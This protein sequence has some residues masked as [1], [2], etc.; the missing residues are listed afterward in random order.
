MPASPRICLGLCLAALILLC[1]GQLRATVLRVEAP[2]PELR[3][4]L[5]DIF[6]KNQPRLEELTGQV[7][8]AVT[9]EAPASGGA[10]SA[11]LQQLG[12]PAWAAGVALPAYHLIL[13]KP[14]HLLYGG[15]DMESLLVHE[16]AHLY[17]SQALAG[18]KAPWW[19]SEGLA[20]L[21]AKESSLGRQYT[22]GKAVFNNGLLP[23]SLMDDNFF[24]SSLQVELAYAE[25]YY[26]AQFLEEQAPGAL[27]KIISGLGRGY[28]V[29]RCLF[30]ATGKTLSQ[31]EHNFAGAMQSRFYW[32]AFGAGGGLW[33]FIA[34]LAALA[35]VWR[36]RRIVRQMRQM[37]QTKAVIL[38]VRSP[39]ARPG[40]ELKMSR[41]MLAQRPRHL[42]E[43]LHR[44]ANGR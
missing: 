14:P 38:L 5:E 31:W 30:E 26:M 4:H 39:F 13:I 28:D 24:P 1:A 35:L 21:A 17:I 7:L 43:I 19:L 6:R 22:M 11:R 9:I 20:M 18:A 37:G 32:L 16:A 44:M 36:R 12:A 10:M 23:L 41:K 8:P 33:V 27:P 29:N 15:Q 2:S 40:Q 25:A 34:L 3:V 42:D